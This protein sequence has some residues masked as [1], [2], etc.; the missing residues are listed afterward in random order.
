MLSTD[1]FF[2]LVFILIPVTWGG[3]FIAG[4]YVIA[5]IDP[6]AGVLIRFVLSGLLML[7]WLAIL[8]RKAHPNFKDLQYLKHL[9]LV[10]ITAGIGYHLFFFWALKYTSP[11]NT[12]IIIAL[13]PFFTAFAERI[14]FKH[15]RSNRFY[16]GFVIAFSG[17]LWVN[18]ARG[19]SIDLSSLGMGELFCL[20]AALLW[21]AYAILAKLTRKDHFDS[22]WTNAYNYLFTGILLIPFAPQLFAME[23]WKGIG[24]PAWLGLWY[25]IIFPTTIGYTMFY[26][27]VIRKGP[28]WASTFIYLVPSITANLDYLFFDAK[29]TISMV[30]GTTMV[31]LGLLYG[32]L[33]IKQIDWMLRKIGIKLNRTR[34]I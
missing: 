32:N 7:P 33:G 31:V 28:A 13:N 18:I 29:L 1:R 9:V 3:S 30:A 5:D 10:I 25:M 34:Y 24:V 26:I 4:K 19:G 11:T 20:I 16:L 14:I 23:F 2:S 6:V 22:L 15:K 12:A 21:S 17:A 8:H 27:G